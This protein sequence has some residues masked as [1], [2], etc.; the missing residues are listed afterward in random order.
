MLPRPFLRARSDERL[1]SD[2][3][4]PRQSV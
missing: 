2:G 3:Q 1:N 4:E